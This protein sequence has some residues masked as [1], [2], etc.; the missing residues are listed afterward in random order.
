MIGKYLNAYR[1][2]NAGL[3]PPPGWDDW[4]AFINDTFYNG[5]SYTMNENGSLVS[6]GTAAADYSTDVVANKT[7]QFLDAA[8]Q[9]PS[10]PFFTYVAP[11]APHLPLPPPPRYASNQWSNAVAPQL[12]NFYEPDLSD[13]PSWLQVGAAYRDGWK[14]NI[15]IDYRNRMGSLLALDDL[16]ANVVQHLDQNGQLPNTYIVLTSDNG[17]ELGSHHLN[18]KLAPYEESVRIPLVVAGPGISFR[19]DNHMVL[20]SDLAPTLLELAGVQPTSAMD[21]PSLVPLLNGTSPASWRRDIL[22]ERRLA[23]APGANPA[24]YFLL[25]ALFDM[26]SYEAVRN[27]R[28]KFVEWYEQN[29]IGGKHE[30]ELYDLWTDPYEQTNLIKTSAGLQQNAAIVSVMNQRLNALRTCLGAACQ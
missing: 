25:G 11:T 28:Y 13:K 18:G 23:N 12:P 3:A 7:T 22:I 30:Y 2:T 21:M 17:Y 9:T 27:L 26:P 1:D 15:D 5:Y 14:P 16:V 10:Q 20:L 6:Y 29:E 4:R 24:N 8:A 19:T